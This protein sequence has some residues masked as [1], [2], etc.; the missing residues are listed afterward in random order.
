[1]ET[2]PEVSKLMVEQVMPKMLEVLGTTP[3]DPATG[4]GFGCNGCHGIDMQ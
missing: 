2:H 4:Q 3:F 1:M